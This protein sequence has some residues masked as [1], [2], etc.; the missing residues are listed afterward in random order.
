M[1][2]FAATAV[3]DAPLDLIATATELYY[4][5]GQPTDRADAIAKKSAAAIT[6]SSGDF[7]KSTSGANRVLTVASKTT[8]AT[9]GQNTDHWALCNGTT[10]LYVTTA[11]AQNTN[12][13]S[14]V[15]SAAVTITSPAVV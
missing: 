2:K 5:N 4:C 15:G 1:S 3:L 14:S 12:I 7:T 11:P 13:G 9:V 10:L 6:M 8:T